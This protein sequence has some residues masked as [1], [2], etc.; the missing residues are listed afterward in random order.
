M[1]TGSSEVRASI[2]E[3]LQAIDDAPRPRVALHFCEDWEA[4]CLADYLAAWRASPEAQ[5]PDY[6]EWRWDWL[7]ARLHD[8]A[9]AA[10]VEAA[11]ERLCEA[12]MPKPLA[13]P[14]GDDESDIPF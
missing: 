7:D 8:E 10:D 12:A 13:S 9:Q 11:E 3:R 14:C 2:C 1:F 4:E 6:D 5:L